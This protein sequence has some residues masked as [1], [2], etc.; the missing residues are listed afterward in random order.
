MKQQLIN[1]VK[2]QMAKVGEEIKVSDEELKML[3]AK[4]KVEKKF[5]ELEDLKEDLREDV[6]YSII[7]LE[8]IAMMEENRNAELKKELEILKYRGQVIKKFA[9]EKL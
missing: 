5:Y 4:L 9:D 7:A 3:V 8:N 1:E 6:K 2:N